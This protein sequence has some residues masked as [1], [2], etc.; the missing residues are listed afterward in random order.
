MKVPMNPQPQHWNPAVE[1]QV[2][3]GDFYQEYALDT[4]TIGA[5]G[6]PHT[7]DYEGHTSPVGTVDVAFENGTWYWVLEEPPAFED[8]E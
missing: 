4:P 5:F 3:W 6:E 7:T 1:T 8:I 2:S